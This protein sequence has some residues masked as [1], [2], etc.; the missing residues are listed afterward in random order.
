MNLTLSLPIEMSFR[1]GQ[2]WVYD[3][4][5]L[6]ADRQLERRMVK[7]KPRQAQYCRGLQ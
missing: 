2:L 5:A 1:K 3:E 7:G 4:E 6:L